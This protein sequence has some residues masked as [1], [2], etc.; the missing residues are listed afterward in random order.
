MVPQD[1]HDW[2]SS[3]AGFAVIVVNDELVI[4]SCTSFQHNRN[5]AQSAIQHN[6]TVLAQGAELLGE[7]GRAKT[8]RARR[9]RHTSNTQAENEVPHPHD[10]VACGFTKTNPCCMSVS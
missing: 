8:S 9:P 5:S 4:S 2:V 7:G 6:L 10:F 3:G 1:Q